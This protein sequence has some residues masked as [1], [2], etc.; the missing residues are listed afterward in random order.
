MRREEKDGNRGWRKH[1]EGLLDLR[2]YPYYIIVSYYGVC[3]GMRFIS[4]VQQTLDVRD[5]LVQIKLSRTSESLVSGG[6]KVCVVPRT[7]EIP[8]IKN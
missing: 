7:Y 8:A 6:K 3:H 4:A 2:S 1:S 5:Y